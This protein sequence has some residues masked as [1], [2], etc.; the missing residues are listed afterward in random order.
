M[1]I[2]IKVFIS[3]I[4]QLNGLHVLAILDFKFI[5]LELDLKR[6]CRRMKMFM[7]LISWL[8]LISLFMV[9]HTNYYLTL[10]ALPPLPYVI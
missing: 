3:V 5:F 8:S 10:S 6:I 2:S 7:V 1:Q 9:S 4:Q